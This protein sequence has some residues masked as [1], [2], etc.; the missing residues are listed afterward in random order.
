[1]GDRLFL[2]TRLAISLSLIFL[3]TACG[4]TPRLMAQERLFLDLSLE[5]I[6]EYQ[7]PK[8]SFEDTT[9]G[10]LSA[11]SY[12]RQKSL[13][14]VLSD[15]RSRLA[16]ARFYTLNIEITDQIDNIEI[17]KVTFLTNQQGETFPPD[18]LDPEGLAITPRHTLFISSEGISD[19]EIPAFIDE[20]NLETGKLETSLRIPQ[21][22]FPSETG[23]IKNNLGF[24][25][26]TVTPGGL[27][28]DDP[29]RLFT[30]TES[31][32]LQDSLETKPDNQ[33]RIRL[34]HYTINSIGDPVLVAEHLYLLEPSNNDTI[35]NGL[36]ELIAL[37][38]EG[39]LL[40]LERTFGLSGFGAK[41][42]QVV[43]AN[44]TDTSRIES[45]KG[46]ISKV[47]PIQKKLILD[48]AELPIELDNLEGMTMG[49]RLADGSQTLLLV[50]DDNFRNQQVN[51][52]LLFRLQEK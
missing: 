16:P 51:Q 21:R 7:L 19:Q 41:I 2:L 45:L 44:G 23:G 20:F 9:V 39:Y 18:S 38:K 5:F 15:D 48:L 35:S 42:F 22:Y 1:M 40:S 10:G 52:F 47:E 31:A 24:E 27:I 14:Y 17:E 28:P 8:T 6:G 4:S 34:M 29:F 49:P 30:A 13:F 3:V 33:N 43:V 12:D 32:L 50:S 25:A 36:T 26:L 11:I 46:D 37:E